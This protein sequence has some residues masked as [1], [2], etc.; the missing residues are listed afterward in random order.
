MGHSC[1]F[2][3]LF[4]G[5]GK[6]WVSCMSEP[7][8]NRKSDYRNRGRCKKCRLG[9]CNVE[10]L[11]CQTKPFAHYLVSSEEPSHFIIRKILQGE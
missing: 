3:L 5:V 7:S 1:A 6:E 10:H 9:S 4:V 8:W 11:K 2:T